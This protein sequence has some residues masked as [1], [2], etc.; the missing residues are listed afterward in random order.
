LEIVPISSPW[1]LLTTPS[2]QDLAVSGAWDTTNL[3][4]MSLLA[5]STGDQALLRRPDPAL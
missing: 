2:P 5:A 4:D 1:P 3:G